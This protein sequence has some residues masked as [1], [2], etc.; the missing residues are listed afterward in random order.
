[1]EIDLL[2]AVHFDLHL[3]HDVVEMVL[4]PLVGQVDQQLLQAV[5]QHVL[6]AENI[7]EADDWVLR[8]I[9]VAEPAVDDPNDLVEQPRVHGLRER[10]AL[11]LR[12]FLV[13]ARQ[14]GAVTYHGHLPVRQRLQHLVPV[15][16]KQTARSLEVRL[17][18]LGQLGVVGGLV[19]ALELR[20]PQVEASPDAVED[21]A[22]VLRLEARL[23]HQFLQGAEGAKVIE[24]RAVGLLDVIGD[25]QVLECF[26]SASL[27]ERATLLLRQHVHDVVVPFPSGYMHKARPLEKVVVDLQTAHDQWIARRQLL[28]RAARGRAALEVQLRVLAEPRGIVVADRLGVAEGLQELVGRRQLLL[29]RVQARLPDLAPRPR[30]C[31]APFSAYV[32]QVPQHLA[33]R[34]GLPSAGLAADDHGLPHGQLV[35]P[36]LGGRRPQALVDLLDGAEAVGAETLP[37]GGNGA[38]L[39]LFP[40]SVL[41]LLR[42]A[43][44]L[45][46]RVEGDQHGAHLAVDRRDHGRIAVC[47]GRLL[48]GLGPLL[49]LVESLHVGQ[50]D[51]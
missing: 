27:P 39:A 13:H 48:A 11:R 37:R 46:A 5:R 26:E 42:V 36:G 45:L 50:H 41:P 19:R 3:E 43:G 15:D 7:E 40:E 34:H 22:L 49:L 25:T 2:L 16:P 30:P 12:L 47:A 4:D 10:V 44:Q 18:P 24:G 20:V 29:A 23:A 21:Q 33:V 32:Q 17:G 28:A 9:L 31:S 35:G 1:M 38:V 6:E 51:V 14:D 8:I